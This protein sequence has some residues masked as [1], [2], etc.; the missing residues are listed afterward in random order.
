MR[1]RHGLLGLLLVVV[2]VGSQGQYV[3]DRRAG[4]SAAAEGVKMGGANFLSGQWSHPTY[5]SSLA[6]RSLSDLRSSTSANWIA[7]TYC[8]FQWSVESTGPIYA[9]E[10]TPTKEELAAIVLR[11]REKD[12]K[13]LFRPCVDPDWSNPQ[14]K[15]T[16]RGEIGTGFSASQWATWFVNY[17][18]LMLEQASIAASLHADAF[19]V[20]ME[21]VLASHQEKPFRVLI[22]KVRGV[23]SG[24]L[25]YC[26]NHGNENSVRFWDAVDEISVDAY[27]SL[28][29]QLESPTVPDLVKAWVPIT[30]SLANLSHTFGDKPVFFAEIGYC[31]I[32]QANA[33]P[34]HCGDGRELDLQAQTNLYQAFFEA[35]WPEEWFSGVFWWA[36]LAD[37]SNGGPTNA[38]FTP[39]GKPAAAVMRKFYSALSS[40]S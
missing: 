23:F 32:I 31:S 26:A 6:N 30:K 20:G 3:S 12:M 38:G 5:N 9:R 17:E 2:I 40:Q 39:A 14:T 27:Y 15:G 34:A 16:W 22:E 35:V 36:W 28:A 19:A 7:L 4:T 1:L 21:L 33:F 29:P 13:V 11:A 18:R 24:K 37:P 10:S 25:T 8:H